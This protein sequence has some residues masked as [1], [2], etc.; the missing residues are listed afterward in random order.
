MA[1][2][3]PTETPETAEP[4]AETPTPVQ[5][6]LERMAAAAGNEESPVDQ[7]SPYEQMVA[8]RRKQL[9]Q[10]RAELEQKRAEL[11]SKLSGESEGEK[12]KDGQVA[13]DADVQRLMSD[14]KGFLAEVMA[15]G[16]EAGKKMAAP[17]EP[18]PQEPEKPADPFADIDI[19]LYSG[20]PAIKALIEEQQRL[21]AELASRDSAAE[22]NRRQRE[23]TQAVQKKWADSM[24]EVRKHA[25]EVDEQHLMRIAQSVLNAP[26]AQTAY[27]IFVY[28]EMAK[29]Q[30]QQ[31]AEEARKQ[32]SVVH[33]GDSGGGFLPEEDLDWRATSEQVVARALAQM[34]D[35]EA[36][37]AL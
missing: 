23:A 21:R 36:R 35:K 28:E 18:A 30:A 33:G 20:D 27:K 1:D 32:L 19:D 13:S 34:A 4:K 6:A 5:A 3:E 14:P 17:Q 24:A 8:D 29:Q 10:E 31:E 22:T 7:L 12:P 37:K 26:D 9:E 25:P 16:I 15:A 2:T 11:E